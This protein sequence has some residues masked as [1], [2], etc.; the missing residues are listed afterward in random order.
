MN[1]SI[2]NLP[3]DEESKNIPEETLE[4]SSSSELEVTKSGEDLNQAAI[5][6]ARLKRDE[7]ALNKL[8]QELNIEQPKKLEISG[9]TG[10]EG[11]RMEHNKELGKSLVNLSNEVQEFEDI[12]RLNKFNRVPLHA[13]DLKTIIKDE[14]IDF[15]TT[16]QVFDDLERDLSKDFMPK[17]DRDRLSIESHNFDR[18]I[19]SL[20]RLRG[21]FS[22]TRNMVDK[23]LVTESGLDTKRLSDSIQRVI[24]IIRRKTDN[25]EEVHAALRRYTGR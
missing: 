10:S 8:R 5:K 9:D 23:K 4:S 2:F 22:G 19:D 25:L 16:L 3:P 18:V 24:N 11:I 20:N 12:L 6:E 13:D 1:E 7:L 15:P 17:D 14:Q 21:I